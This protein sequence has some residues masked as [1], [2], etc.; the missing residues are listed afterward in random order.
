MPADLQ[1]IM[2]A[3]E[4]AAA[5]NDFPSAARHLREAAAL[6]ESALG[7]VHPELANTLNNL[8]V[9]CERIGAL[10]EAERSFKRA[11]A[12]ATSAFPADH[13]FFETSRANLEE[14]CRLHGRSFEESA[15]PD[16]QEEFPAEPVATA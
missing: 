16:Q 14:F 15:A 12:I 4:Q 13:P 8:G 6:Q 10:D 3:A 11:Y 2:D 9:V 7:P 5:S 1:A